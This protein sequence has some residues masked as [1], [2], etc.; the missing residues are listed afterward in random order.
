MPKGCAGICGGSRT[1]R[2]YVIDPAVCVSC[3]LCAAHCP[4]GVIHGEVPPY[5]YELR[6]VV[7][8]PFSIEADK[9]LGCG[10]CQDWCRVGA[11]RCP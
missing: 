4:V 10:I 6:D 11:I 1:G 3:G 5:N 9:C 2:P 8:T 7:C